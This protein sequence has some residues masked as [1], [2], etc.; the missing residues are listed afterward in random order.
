[1]AVRASV[2]NA[3]RA[4]SGAGELAARSAL[5]A[6]DVAA[7]SGCPAPLFIVAARAA[8]PGSLRAVSAPVGPV[9]CIA[10]TGAACSGEI[11]AVLRPECGAGAG[12][13]DGGPGAAAATSAFRSLPESSERGRTFG[14]ASGATGE[15]APA[16]GAV[17]AEAAGAG[18]AAF[19][20]WLR[21]G[22]TGTRGRKTR[23]AFASE[24]EAPAFP[25]A[26]APA[27]AGAFAGPG[28]PA[29]AGTGS[30]PA[31]VPAENSC[32]S[33]D[34]A[35]L[36]NSRGACMP[37]FSVAAGR[38]A[39][40]SPASARHGAVCEGPIHEFAGTVS[41]AAGRSISSPNAGPASGTWGRVPAADNAAALSPC[42]PANRDAI[43][44]CNE[45]SSVRIRCRIGAVAPGGT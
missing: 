39:N 21:R 43:P 15:K 42:G 10:R 11:R 37:L 12:P 16:R 34:V 45:I 19:A 28:T 36:S 7:G 18:L 38:F 22:A 40:C 35:E 41:T 4:G 32:V 8:L 30:S 5:A 29:V 23:G 2:V 6:D 14:S 3:A 1:M 20:G 24:T 9:L 13:D 33:V 26:G 17:L 25:A 31:F 44:G 27:G